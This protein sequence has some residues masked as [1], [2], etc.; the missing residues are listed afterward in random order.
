MGCSAVD[1]SRMD[2]A[3]IYPCLCNRIHSTMSLLYT[4]FQALRHLLCT[5]HPPH[6]FIIPTR[7]GEFAPLNDVL[8]IVVHEKLAIAKH[9]AE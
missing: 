9:R 8:K 4:Y 1:I 3:P 6:R 2:P 7:N 5:I